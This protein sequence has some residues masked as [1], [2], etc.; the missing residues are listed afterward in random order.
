MT[1]RL[2]GLFSHLRNSGVSLPADL[3]DRPR[4]NPGVIDTSPAAADCPAFRAAQ[5]PNSQVMERPPPSKDTLPP[6]GEASVQRTSP[7]RSLWSIRK[8]KNHPIIWIL[9]TLICASGVSVAIFGPTR[10]QNYLSS[11]LERFS[12]SNE[13][14]R[15]A[16]AGSH[17]T[18]SEFGLVPLPSLI[19]PDSSAASSSSQTAAAADTAPT[20]EKV[21]P[22]KDAS[23]W[24]AALASGRLSG[25]RSYMLTFPEGAYYKAALRASQARMRSLKVSSSTTSVVLRRQLLVQELPGRNEAQTS[26]GKVGEVYAVVMI[27]APGAGHWYLFKGDGKWPFRFA[28]ESDVQKATADVFE[29]ALRSKDEAD[30]DSFYPERARATRKTGTALLSLS[31]SESGAVSAVR[32]LS[33]NPT[34]LG[35]GQAAMKYAKGLHFKPAKKNGVPVET[36][37]EE[38][39]VF[40]FGK[41][42]P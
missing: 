10:L 28:S 27:E 11:V 3:D 9:L 19:N 26:Y 23:A 7:K 33:E 34:G 40:T 4:P 14:V 42:Q 41:R 22:D 31:I 16:G 25:F 29:Q 36:T 32:L 13:D 8:K 21:L 20:S 2:A 12:A 38:R 39:V 35:F 18:S 17:P 30:P 6:R 15:V 24:H 5:A 37:L 1:G